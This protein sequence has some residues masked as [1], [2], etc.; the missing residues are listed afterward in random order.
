M[1]TTQILKKLKSVDSSLQIKPLA[2]RDREQ[3]V[4]EYRNKRKSRK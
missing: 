1:S 3:Y 4:H 2:S